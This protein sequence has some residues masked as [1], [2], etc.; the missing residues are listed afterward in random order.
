MYAVYSDVSLTRLIYCLHP[1]FPT[2]SRLLPPGEEVTISY[3][4]GPQLLPLDARR[5]ALSGAFGFDC[6][7]PRCRAEQ[8]L[9]PG[10]ATLLQDTASR[11]SRTCTA[12]GSVL[13]VVYEGGLQGCLTVAHS[14]ATH[15]LRNRPANEAR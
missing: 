3:L 5:E 4:G 15:C 6:G 12:A 13:V 9:A 8:E 1:S 2:S 14:L 7:C 10:L 11:V